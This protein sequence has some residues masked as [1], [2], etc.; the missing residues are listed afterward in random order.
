VFIGTM[1]E[2]PGVGASPYARSTV[3]KA[4]SNQGTIPEAAA[5]AGVSDV[6]DG[7]IAGRAYDLHLARGGEHGYD[8]EDWLQ[9]ERELRYPM[10][11]V[12]A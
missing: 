3:A 2:T 6:T 12:I 5:S 7:D 9:A 4:K 11:S 1:R 10:P 8:M